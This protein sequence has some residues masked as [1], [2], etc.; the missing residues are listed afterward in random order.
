[1]AQLQKTD[2]LVLRTWHVQTLLT[3]VGV[4]IAGRCTSEPHPEES[5]SASIHT[6][7]ENFSHFE[8]IVGGFKIP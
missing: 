5:V 8:H 7:R 3:V 4:F 2:T 6:F 1:M